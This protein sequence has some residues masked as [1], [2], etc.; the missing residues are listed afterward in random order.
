M[1]QTAKHQPLKYLQPG[2]YTKLDQALD[3]E[4]GLFVQVANMASFIGQLRS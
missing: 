4:F 2:S 1:H 3:E